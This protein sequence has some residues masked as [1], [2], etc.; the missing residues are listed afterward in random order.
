MGVINAIRR[1]EAPGSEKKD[2]LLLKVIGVSSIQHLYCFSEPEVIVTHRLYYKMGT[3]SLGNPI[4]LIVRS[5]PVW[6]SPLWQT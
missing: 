3:M 2:C 1:H 6:L 5:K 4:Y